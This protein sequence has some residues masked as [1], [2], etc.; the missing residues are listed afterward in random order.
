[1]KFWASG[2]VL[3]VLLV[4]VLLLVAELLRRFVPPLRNLGIPGSIIAGAVGLA[5]GPSA[6]ALLP[7]DTSVLESAVYHGLAIAFIAVGLQTPPAGQQGG[8]ATSMAFGISWM[9]AFQAFLGLGVV[10]VLGGLHPGLGAML[11][12][13]FQQG[14]GQALAMGA[15]WEEFG[16][17]DG[18][19]LG[20]IVAALGFAWSVF[21]GVP[22]V[23]WG[24][25]KGLI[26][27]LRV[28]TKDESKV[29]RMTLPAGSLELL[30]RQALAIGVVYLITYGIVLLLAQVP[31]L[32]KLVWGFHF[33]I[34]ALVALPARKLLHRMPGPS[35]LDDELLGRLAG[36]TVDFITCSALAAIQISVLTANWMP[37][38]ILTTV[39]GT[40]T[41]VSVIWLARRAFPD[42]PFEHCVVLFGAATG[43]LPMGLA[44]LR[45]IDPDLRSPAPMSAVLGSL[46]AILGGA[47]VVM[48]FLPR[49]V[50]SWSEGTWPGAG[51]MWLGICFV[52][53]VAITIAW[54]L[55]GPL[56]FR[57]PLRAFW[58][59]EA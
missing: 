37:I 21:I 7:L 30:T 23:H 1:M 27:P 53:V 32:S 46:G 38:L 44:L 34:G 51:W 56:R 9:L 16:L 33:L 12:L 5:C 45:I 59:T 31:A 52:Y 35:V 28:D 49:V 14:P 40:M 26:S 3:T 54:R 10:L 58:P 48:V 18:A 39:G 6:L 15:T 50:T 2:L 13:G 41:A 4:A 42:A 17:E 24:R 20:L 29:K 57:K 47:P 19:Q 8:G 36:I 43:T 22:L 11:P 55:I 25:R